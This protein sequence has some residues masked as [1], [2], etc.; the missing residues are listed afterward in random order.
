VAVIVRKDDDLASLDFDRRIIWNLR[1]QAAFDHIVV[2]HHVF[3]AIEQQAAILR[4]DLRED[5]P[6][7]GELGVQK[8]SAFKAND[9]QQI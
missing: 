7:C 2:G 8:D 3:G 1:A 4:R 9:P 5:A 6:R